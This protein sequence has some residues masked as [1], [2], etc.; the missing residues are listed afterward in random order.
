MHDPHMVLG[1]ENIVVDNGTTV[2]AMGETNM[3]SPRLHQDN[4]FRYW[5]GLIDISSPESRPAFV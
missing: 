2:A 5:L 4:P 3:A 1:D